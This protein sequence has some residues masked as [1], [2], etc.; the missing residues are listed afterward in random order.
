MEQF[1]ISRFCSYVVLVSNCMYMHIHHLV[2]SITQTH[3][4]RYVNPLTYMSLRSKVDIE[5]ALSHKLLHN[6]LYIRIIYVYMFILYTHIIYIFI[7]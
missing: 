6:M 2:C 5:R 1:R 4:I 3:I 7:F